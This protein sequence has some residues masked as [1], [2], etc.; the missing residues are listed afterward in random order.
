MTTLKP[1]TQTLLPEGYTM[2][3][4]RLDDLNDAIALFNTCS[5]VLHGHDEFKPE[6]IHF[7]WTMPN[8]Q[9]EKSMRVV[10]TPDGKIVGYIEV[11]DTHARPVHP[12]VWGRVH[13]DHEGRGIGT[14]LLTWAEER[15]QLAIEKCPPEAR[16]S[17][18]V[19]Y[20]S[21]YTPAERLYA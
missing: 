9:L 11:W 15:C 19:G 16:V 13:P 7:E 2:R 14:A 3:P 17:Y 21:G 10:L 5:R 4:A 18:N 6:D 12:W 8:V 20:K 1:I